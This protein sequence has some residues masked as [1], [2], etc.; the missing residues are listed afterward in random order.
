MS[1]LKQ[2]WYQKFDEKLLPVKLFFL[3]WVEP[4]CWVID[5]R[6]KTILDV[7]CGQG[8]P[9]QLLKKRYKFDRIVGVDLFKPYI[10]EC[11]EKKIHDE[12]I[13]SDVRKLL[14]K[15]NSFD[16]VMALQIL[17]HLP[18]KDAW[19]LLAKM[20]KIAAKQ[21]II[22]TP[23]GEMYHPPV[24]GNELQLHLSDF[25]PKEFEKRGYKVLKVGLKELIGEHGLVHQ[26]PNDLVRKFIYSINL[27]VTLFLYFW[28]KK[29]NYYFVATKKMD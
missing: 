20:E 22:A 2:N 27:F 8:L 18:K 26:V 11:K 3:S 4:E 9:M 5:K 19:K 7:G 13:L 12:Y 28:Q 10:K 1:K 24:D 16:V 25:Q 23:I 14:F 15:D 29:A 6:V 17:E 21:V